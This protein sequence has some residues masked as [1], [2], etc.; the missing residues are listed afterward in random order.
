[1]L[2]TQLLIAL[3]LVGPQQV[4]HVPIKSIPAPLALKHPSDEGDRLLEPPEE[5][6]LLHGVQQ[7]LALVLRH[8]ARAEWDI[9]GLPYL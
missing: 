1:M 2:S 8:P 3:P 5:I 4:P 9:H 6:Q 7:F